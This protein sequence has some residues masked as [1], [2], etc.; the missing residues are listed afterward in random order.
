ML[1]L[2]GNFFNPIGLSLVM[3]PP[4]SSLPDLTGIILGHG[5][6]L[7]EEKLDA[8]GNSLA[9]L[10]VRCCE[11]HDYQVSLPH[12]HHGRCSEIAAHHT[13]VSFI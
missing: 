13:L 8:G 5:V 10:M 2:L 11:S 3:A 6:L 7:S 9:Q 12:G 4:F 1:Q